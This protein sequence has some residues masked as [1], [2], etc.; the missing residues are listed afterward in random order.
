ME[1][2][3]QVGLFSRQKEINSNN[4]C[5]NISHSSFF[6]SIDSSLCPLSKEKEEEEEEGWCQDAVLCA[7]VATA[8]AIKGLGA[9]V[10][11]ARVIELH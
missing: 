2:K 4:R 8:A 5:C 3:S 9:T 11:V 6:R 7:K 1:L 10:F